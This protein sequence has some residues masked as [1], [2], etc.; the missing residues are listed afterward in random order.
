MAT[1]RTSLKV[2]Q[3]IGFKNEILKNK[4]RFLISMKNVYHE[5]WCVFKP[6]KSEKAY[7]YSFCQTEVSNLF[8]FRSSRGRTKEGAIKLFALAIMR[9]EI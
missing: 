4:L 5:K 2:I 8:S 1:I 7:Y 3:L 9:F 6:S